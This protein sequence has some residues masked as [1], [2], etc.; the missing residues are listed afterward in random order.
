MA[1]TYAGLRL[2]T[3]S[4]LELPRWINYL[5]IVGF[6]IAG[7]ACFAQ[8]E[9]FV[10]WL[11]GPTEQSLINEIK[12]SLVLQQSVAKTTN[13]QVQEEPLRF[14]RFSERN[15]QDLKD[16]YGWVL[17]DK[18]LETR[19]N[20]RFQTSFKDIKILVLPEW[21]LDRDGWEKDTELT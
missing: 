17:A 7:L 3:P 12:D 10:S 21:E 18:E 9:M 2:F 19:F 20:K 1:D 15:I 13:A 11:P 14:A 6:F 5:F 8:T 4:D 16:A